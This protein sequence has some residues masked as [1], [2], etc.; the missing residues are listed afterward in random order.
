MEE[1]TRPK[2]DAK[3]NKIRIIAVAAIVVILV[4]A[5]FAVAGLLSPGAG[6]GDVPKFNLGDEWWYTKQEGSGESED[7]YLMTKVIGTLL[8]NG[9]RFYQV[10]Q[11]GWRNATR[12]SYESCNMAQS[13]LS[14][15]DGDGYFESEPFDFPL[16]DG[17]EWK[18]LMGGVKDYSFTC[19]R[20]SSYQVPAGKFSGFKITA[21]GSS[22]SY[23][24]WYSS[25][26]KYLIA[27]SYQPAAGDEVNESFEYRLVGYGSRDGD[28]DGLSD[29]GEKIIGSDPSIRD[30]DGDGVLDGNDLN[31]LRDLSFTFELIHLTVEDR[32]DIITQSDVFIDIMIFAGTEYVFERTDTYRNQNDIDLNLIYEFDIADDGEPGST[33]IW[34]ELNFWEEKEPSSGG[35]VLDVCAD[36]STTSGYHFYFYYDIFKQEWSLQSSSFYEP[37]ITGSGEYTVSGLEDGFSAIEE[38]PAQDATFTFNMF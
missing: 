24:F 18:G 13:N 7:T 4:L 11:T 10:G 38:A 8:M 5:I 15:C 34:G 9:I 37:Y 6:E 12:E 30:T 17:K 32:T 1:E 26:V 3:S 25:K 2:I 21:S 36:P 28:K 27:Y 20:F 35:I 22:G 29:A 14:V 33:Y 16:E 19:D 23:D 31:P